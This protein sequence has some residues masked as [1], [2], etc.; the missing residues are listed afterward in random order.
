VQVDAQGE[1]GEAALDSPGPSQYFANQALTA[2]R[3]WK[4]TPAERGGHAVASQWM[5]TFRFGE[6][7]ATVTAAETAP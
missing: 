3:R 2:T 1:V 6:E 7:G 5:L 4:F